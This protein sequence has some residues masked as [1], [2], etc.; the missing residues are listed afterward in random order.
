MYAVIMMYF[1]FIGPGQM[2]VNEIE[3]WHYLNREWNKNRD[4]FKV[5]T[6]KITKHWLNRVVLW[7]VTSR[8]F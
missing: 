6:V 7:V 2:S 5:S 3:Y 1:F 4:Y 8:M